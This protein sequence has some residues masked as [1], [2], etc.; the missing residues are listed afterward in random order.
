MPNILTCNPILISQLIENNQLP[1]R[2]LVE[3]Y[4]EIYANYKKN[5][6]CRKFFYDRTGTISHYLN[7]DAEKHK[8]PEYSNF[9]LSF[10]EVA[11][12]RAKADKSIA[13]KILKNE[14]SI[15]K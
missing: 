7:I 13:E 2:F 8:I 11:E 10:D 15:I 5:F 4:I 12:K 9:N 6:P 1:K 3:N 14:E